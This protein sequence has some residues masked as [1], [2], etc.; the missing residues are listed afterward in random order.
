[1]RYQYRSFMRGLT[2]ASA[3]TLLSV[4]GT[5]W[6]PI[7]DA[8]SP[9][10][11]IAGV[12][13]AGLFLWGFRML[14]WMITGMIVGRIIYPPELSTQAIAALLVGNTAAYVLAVMHLRAGPFNRE[15]S[16]VSDV[17]RF[18]RAA[19]ILAI[20]SCVIPLILLVSEVTG[21]DLTVRTTVEILAGILFGRFSSAVIVGALI[22]TFKWVDVKKAFT[23]AGRGALLC[24]LSSVIAMA[25]VFG[26]FDLE[27]PITW[28][29]FP[30]LIIASF[31]GGSGL[32]AKVLFIIGVGSVWGTTL[33]FGPFSSDPLGY[34]ILK[35]F[36]AV[37]AATGLILSGTARE[38]L[39]KDIAEQRGEDL[40]FL[41]DSAVELLL[42]TDIAA[43]VR[44]CM[45]ALARRCDMDFILYHSLNGG[46]I[47][48]MRRAADYGLEMNVPDAGLLATIESRVRDVARKPKPMSSGGEQ[49][50]LPRDLSPS[51]M[52]ACFPIFDAEALLGVLSVGSTT[53]STIDPGERKLI[54]TIVFYISAADQRL[55]REAERKSL[56]ES[57][58]AA[59]MEAERAD[60]LKNEFLAVLSHEL[61]NPLNA[62]VGW[63]QLLQRGKVDVSRAA[64]IIEQSARLQ[65]QLIEDLLDMSRIESGKLTVTK[66]LVDLTS[67]VAG[68]CEA[69]RLLAQEKGV[70][71]ELR[72]ESEVKMAAADSV[73]INQIASNLL[74]NAIKFTPPKGRVT[75]SLEQEGDSAVLTVTDTGAGISQDFMPHLF[76][77]F[78]QADQST[79]RRYGGLGLGL[80]IAKHMTELHGGTIEARSPGLGK[81]ATFIVRLPMTERPSVELTS[82]AAEQDRAEHKDDIALRGRSIVVVED[83]TATLEM[84]SRS[85]SD[86]GATVI[87]CQRG[88][89]AL[90]EIRSR[91]P[92]L[93]ISDIGMPDMDGYELMRQLRRTMDKRAYYPAIALTAF[94]RSED[95]DEALKAGFDAH[96]SKPVNLRRLEELANE[97][98]LDRGERV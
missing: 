94:T 11:P 58:R 76:N 45:P 44:R 1:M 7:H 35:Q 82:P 41:S 28:L 20:T 51:G 72:L 79:T 10:T 54:D 95:K 9:V 85:L 21:S 83:D 75:I 77:R 34:A 92:D 23:R 67:L 22:L 78:R 15:L 16:S 49:V 63:T 43:S 4:L 97:L 2:L 55:R 96:L 31:V 6:A 62:I 17:K 71:L 18:L 69:M 59:R 33:G 13:L 50:A 80:A 29:V 90:R 68:A 36:L 81:G 24:L 3:M 47:D 70:E 88:V 37:A 60:R 64:K 86:R 12:A 39:D 25:V 87:T 52:L 93:L 89:D 42:S 5:E 27:R 65:S 26:P 46:G 61:R 98:M 8:F 48:A 19:M 30:P 56:L 57:E 73:R 91:K 38:R 14:P 40:R 66:A 32:T 53:R 84:L 74:S